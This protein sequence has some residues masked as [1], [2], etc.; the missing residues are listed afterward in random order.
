MTEK[1]PTRLDDARALKRMN[2]PLNTPVEHR[3]FSKA[4]SKHWFALMNAHTE[5]MLAMRE[6]CDD[7]D[8]RPGKWKL[9]RRR[10]V[11]LDKAVVRCFD[12]VAELGGNVTGRSR[13]GL[14]VRTGRARIRAARSF[15]RRAGLAFHRVL[16][17]RG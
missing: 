14:Q 15:H 3:T 4:Y 1:P 7:A 11:A 10:F 12:F 5:F 17:R 8:P 2:I 16:G 9:V 6:Y 13:A